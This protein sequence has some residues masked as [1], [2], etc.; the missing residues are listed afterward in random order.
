M[1]THD[2]AAYFV[3]IPIYVGSDCII[4]LPLVF[5]SVAVCLL[6]SAGDGRPM[7]D[8][9]RMDCIA[10]VR[11]SWESWWCRMKLREI[12]VTPLL[13]VRVRTARTTS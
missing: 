7:D 8:R 3:C 9:R 2:G 10:V 5:G 4:V 1:C 12:V 6:S 13:D 11:E